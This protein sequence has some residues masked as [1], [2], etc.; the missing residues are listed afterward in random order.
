MLWIFLPEKSDD[1]N[2]VQ[3]HNLGYQRLACTRPPKLLSS[4][5]TD[6]DGKKCTKPTEIHG[7]AIP[8]SVSSDQKC[9]TEIKPFSSDARYRFLKETRNC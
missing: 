6:K 5:M 8:T 2:R 3:T 7:F 9:T 1:F 4:D